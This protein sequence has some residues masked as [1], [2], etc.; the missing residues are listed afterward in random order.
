MDRGIAGGRRSPALGRVLR[1]VV[2]IS[3]CSGRRGGRGRVFEQAIAG[4]V[5]LELGASSRGCQI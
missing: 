1:G 4:A 5:E 3:G 2:A